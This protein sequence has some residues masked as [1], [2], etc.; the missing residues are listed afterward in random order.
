MGHWRVWNWAWSM[1]G[2]FYLWII[3][4]LW[5]WQTGWGGL[6]G[7]QYQTESL[8]LVGPALTLFTSWIF[9]NCSS[10]SQSHLCTSVV[11]QILAWWFI[12]TWVGILMHLNVQ[13]LFCSLLFSLFKWKDRYKWSSLLLSGE[14]CKIFIKIILN[15]WVIWW[16]LAVLIMLGSHP[17]TW[18]LSPFI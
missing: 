9:Q 1:W 5:S 13:K 8:L 7:V 3:F 2:Q 10:T 6:A 4:T 17:Q 18:E 14:K 12:Y 11:S 16:E 15:L